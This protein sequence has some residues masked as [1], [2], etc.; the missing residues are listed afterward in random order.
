MEWRFFF[1]SLLVVGSSHEMDFIQ[2][3]GHISEA[4]RATNMKVYGIPR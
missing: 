3:E 4:Q 2:A 1:E